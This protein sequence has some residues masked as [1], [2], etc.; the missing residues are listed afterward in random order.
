MTAP[1]A[2][3]LLAMTASRQGG[4]AATALAT[5]AILEGTTVARA[6]TLARAGQLEP[7]D[8]EVDLELLHLLAAALDAF[9]GRLADADAAVLILRGPL[10]GQELAHSI[11]EHQ[12]RGRLMLTRAVLDVPGG[13]IELQG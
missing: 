6:I 10:A 5:V 8:D 3:E 2:S 1:S 4:P 12:D 9:A 11:L 13:P 7:A